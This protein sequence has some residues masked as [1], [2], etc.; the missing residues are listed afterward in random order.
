[1][2]G[3]S[4]NTLIVNLQKHFRERYYVGMYGAGMRENLNFQM[5][6]ELQ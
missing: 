5:S 4:V 1:M 3:L 6:M 2:P